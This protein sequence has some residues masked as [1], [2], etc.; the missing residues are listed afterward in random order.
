MAVLKGKTVLYGDLEVDDSVVIIKDNYNFKHIKTKTFD[1]LFYR[2]TDEFAGLKE[3]CIDYVIFDPWRPLFMYPRWFI[4]AYHDGWMF[5][6]DSDNWVYYD[7]N[8]DV[9]M[10]PGSV[11]LHNRFGELR[12]M[13]RNDFEKYYHTRDTLEED[14]NWE[15][16]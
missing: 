12:Y 13:E 15:V 2:I 16:T 3:D 14:R 7:M 8:G 9:A 10:A 5:E 6:E 4:Q 11:M 1:D